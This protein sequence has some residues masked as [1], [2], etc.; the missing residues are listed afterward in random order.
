MSAQQEDLLPDLEHSA[1][2]AADEVFQKLDLGSGTADAAYIDFAAFTYR[3]FDVP[4]GR[5]WARLLQ[6]K[7]IDKS[8]NRLRVLSQEGRTQ[9]A[10]DFRISGEITDIGATL[11]IHTDITMLEDMSIAASI[12]IDLEKSP[13]ITR[14][15][16]DESMASAD[17]S[18]APD[19]FEGDSRTQP[20]AVTVEEGNISRSLH[21]GDEDWFVLQMENNEALRLFT[22]GSLDTFMS[23]FDEGGS[24]VAENDDMGDDTNSSVT[25]SSSQG[26]TLLVK[27]T[28]YDGSTG[29]YT[30]NI[31][32]SQPVYDQWEPNNTRDTALQLDPGGQDIETAFTSAGDNDWF[33][34]TVSGTEA[35]YIELSTSGDHDTQATLY[36]D[37]MN[38]IGYNDDGDE[39]YNTR[40]GVLINEGT[41]YLEITEINNAQGPYGLHLRTR[42]YEP[43]QWE[44][45]NSILKPRPIKRGDRHTHNFIP[46]NDRDWV[47]FTV[48]TEGM[49][50]LYTLGP[51]D[52]I[53]TLYNTDGEEIASDD[54]SGGD[55]N[56]RI[57]INLPAGAYFLELAE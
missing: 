22:T 4:L 26:S 44:P 35:S 40:L 1:G 54:D 6:D 5:I 46:E 28:G 48:E 31:E 11:L 47:T 10:P 57:D 30:L 3:G 29:N 38:Q 21:P 55:Y 34:F 33:Y 45:D 49:V 7:I 20:V 8:A 25:V 53:M 2:K 51:V 13:E 52:T 17:G 56:A 14:L 39:D 23:V 9:R 16:I 50:S 12:R 27:I 15:L 37:A 32:P 36:D 41:Y 43:D 18:V 42:H 19:P 24:L